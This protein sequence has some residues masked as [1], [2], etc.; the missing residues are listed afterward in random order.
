MQSAKTVAA[1]TAALLV[2]ALTESKATDRQVALRWSHSMSV[3]PFTYNCYIPEIHSLISPSV[4][5]PAVDLLLL[6]ELCGLLGQS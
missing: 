3:A 4:D 5:F 1:L 2:I 6:R